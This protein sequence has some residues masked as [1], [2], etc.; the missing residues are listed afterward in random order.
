MKYTILG[1][2][3][4]TKTVKCSIVFKALLVNCSVFV[5]LEN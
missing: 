2:E 5:W 3:C 4:V 1:F